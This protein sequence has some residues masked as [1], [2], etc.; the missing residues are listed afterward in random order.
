MAHQAL[1]AIFASARRPKRVVGAVS[2]KFTSFLMDRPLGTNHV[3]SQWGSIRNRFFKTEPDF[4][5]R[6]GQLCGQRAVMQG[7][8]QTQDDPPCRFSG[9]QDD[10]GIY[11]I[12]SCSWQ[13]TWWNWFLNLICLWVFWKTK[14]LFK[15]L[16]VAKLFHLLGFEPREYARI[17]SCEKCCR[18]H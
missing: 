5:N 18:M 15:F 3:S 10:F 13:I 2:A 12:P 14:L 9:Q 4:R 8:T 6:T 16:H 1:C 7:W 11:R 17:V